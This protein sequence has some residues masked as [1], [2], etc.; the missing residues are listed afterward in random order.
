L[1]LGTVTVGGGLSVA[2]GAG[3]AMMS[4]ATTWEHEVP[5]L[6]L[7]STVCLRLRRPPVLGVGEEPVVVED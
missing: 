6:V 1:Y 4:A 3:V 5:P 7:E 2:A